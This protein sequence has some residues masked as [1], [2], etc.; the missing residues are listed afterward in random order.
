MAKMG[1]F[2]AF[3][4]AVALLVEKGMGHILDETYGACLKELEKPLA[5]IQNPVTAIYEPFSADEISD[6]ISELLTPDGMGSEVKI[7]FQSIEGLHKAC[8]DH[9][10]DWYFTGKY[11]TP[12]GRRVVNKAF[13][14]F[15]EGRTERAY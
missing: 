6:K 3:Q 4:A 8:P 1:D 13:V 14:Y 12:G 10:G 7:I 15:M 11:P 2:I 5:E 9:T